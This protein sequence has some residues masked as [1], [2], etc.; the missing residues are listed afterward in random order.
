MPGARSSV[1]TVVAVSV[2]AYA[3][4]DLVH[5]ALGHGVACLFIHSVRPISISSVALQMDGVSRAVAASG[6]VA[7]LLVGLGVL[8]A[9]RFAHRFTA[10]TF[11]AWL[12][13]ATD[14]M[15]ATGYL[16]FSGITNIGDW[17]VVIRNGSPLWAWRLR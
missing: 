1:W 6:T 4:C 14:L 17:A 10:G 9:L 7:N 15:N 3:A 13:A 12:L 11:F 5:E 16:V 2:V 8:I